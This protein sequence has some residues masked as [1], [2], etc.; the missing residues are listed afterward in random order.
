MRLLNLNGGFYSEKFPGKSIYLLL[1][2]PS[3]KNYN[4]NLLKDKYTFAVKEIPDTLYPNPTFWCLC[5]SLPKFE[6][7]ETTWQNPN[8]IKFISLQIWNKLYRA[9]KDNVKEDWKYIRKCPNTFKFP[10]LQDYNYKTFLT[11]DAVCWGLEKSDKDVDGNFG[12]RSIMFVALKL[13]YELGFSKV[14]LLGCDFNMTEENAYA[15]GRAKSRHAS[16]QNNERYKVWTKRLKRLQQKFIENDFHVFN[17]NPDS[18][19]EVFPF[20]E[21]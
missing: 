12:S 4:L 8:I 17:C 14:F 5:E 2:G 11:H 15:S 20:A 13:I 9:R 16:K 6:Y 18:N 10:I 19:L 3:L 21:Y 7:S 1:T